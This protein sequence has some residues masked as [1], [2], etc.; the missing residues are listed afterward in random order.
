MIDPITAVTLATSAFNAVKKLVE[1]GREIEDCAGYLGKFFDGA[2]A[3]KHAEQKA[4]NPPLFKKFLAGGS[5][6]QQ[7]LEITMH[8]QKLK[9]METELRQMILYSYGMDVYNE[10]I[11]ERERI[12]EAQRLQAL[13]AAEFKENLLWSA[14]VAALLGLLVFLLYQI[15]SM[16]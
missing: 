8:R 16:L 6:E 3:I 9:K 11:R 7:A 4:L 1:T 14:A 13:R 5:I 10:M 15:F 12:R 2:S